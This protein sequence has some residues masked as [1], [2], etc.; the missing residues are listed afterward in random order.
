M[1]VEIKTECCKA[2]KRGI[3]QAGVVIVPKGTESHPIVKNIQGLFYAQ[4]PN[5]TNYD[6]YQF[7]GT[8]KKTCIESWNNYMKSGGDSL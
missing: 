5:C 8:T 4:C 7:L 3:K 6:P 2:C 1:C